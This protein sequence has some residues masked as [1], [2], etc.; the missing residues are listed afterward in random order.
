[1]KKTI[2]LIATAQIL[3]CA[4][5]HGTSGS[6]ANKSLSCQ[7]SGQESTSLASNQKFLTQVTDSDSKLNAAAIVAADS[8]NYNN[9]II[10]YKSNSTTAGSLAPSGTPVRSYVVKGITFQHVAHGTY[11][12]SLA[13]A[14]DKK[15]KVL[16]DL[17]SEQDVEFIEPDYPIYANQDAGNEDFLKTA[18]FNDQWALP[19]VNLQAAWGVTKGSND[20]VI[21][22]LDSGIDYTHSDLKN[23]MW[24]NPKEVIN[25]FD[26]DGNGLIDDVYGWNFVSNNSNPKTSA[27]S[28]HGSHVAGIIGANRGNGQ[29]ILGMAPN[30]KMMAL[31]FIG[32]NGSGSTSD[33]I[34]GIDYA[35]SKKVFAINNS[36]GSSGGSRALSDAIGR[37]EHAGVLMVV[38]AGNGSGGIG[39]SID[40]Q[41]WYPASYKNS[42]VLNVAATGSS[43]FLTSFSNFG[44]RLVDVAAPGLNILST[45]SNQGYQTMSGTSMAAP[46]VTG[47]AVLVKAANPALNYL[48]V[49]SVIRSSV[50]KF[51]SLTGRIGAGGRVNALRAVQVA[52]ANIGK[53][54]TG[55]SIVAPCP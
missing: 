12:F 42:N 50:D 26:D 35:I 1:M 55:G 6:P 34:R 2:L 31:K 28:N 47:L 27:T 18:Q 29:G 46:L 10:K 40:N 22:V 11:S 7:I 41:G 32:E 21:A 9:F 38:A 39:Y 49:I 43:D 33:A 54:L 37:A 51:T 14:A 3:G 15:Q 30:V 13:T 48:Q 8:G 23:N 17:A 5:D 20:I 19:K 44:T 24:R 45:V 16:A 52:A 25:G 36:W 53:N 4:A